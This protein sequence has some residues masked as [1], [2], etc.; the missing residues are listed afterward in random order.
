MDES[1]FPTSEILPFQYSLSVDD[2][3]NRV[4]AGRGRQGRPEQFERL[5]RSCGSFVGLSSLFNGPYEGKF[6]LYGRVIIF[7]LSI[8][9][10]CKG[11]TS[12]SFILT[13]VENTLIFKLIAQ[14]SSTI[15]YLF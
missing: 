9:K 2:W 8:N 7:S 6:V 12:G 15:M 14:Y 4:G 5:A 3:C 13:Y 11:I 10:L 1:M